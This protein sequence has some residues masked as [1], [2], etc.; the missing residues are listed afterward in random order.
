M[1]MNRFWD[2]PAEAAGPGRDAMY[3][4]TERHPDALDLAPIFVV[5]HLAIGIVML[6]G[7]LSG[8]M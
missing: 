7:Y 3:S 8:W 1:T 5:A 6:A 2:A 4:L